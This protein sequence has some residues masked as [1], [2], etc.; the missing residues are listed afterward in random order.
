MAN[1][2]VRAASDEFETE[3]VCIPRPIERSETRRWR[4]ARVSR[5]RSREPVAQGQNATGRSIFGLRRAALRSG[6]GAGG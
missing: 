2:V 3:F 6:V 4:P 5:A 1:T